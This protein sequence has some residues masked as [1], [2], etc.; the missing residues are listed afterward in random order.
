MKPIS[1]TKRKQLL[2]DYDK[3][4]GPSNIELARKYGVSNSCIRYILKNAGVYVRQRRTLIEQDEVNK[5]K[6]ENNTMKAALQ[7]IADW[8]LPDTGQFW[9]EKKKEPK[10]YT[11]VHGTNGA[12]NVMRCVAFDALGK[13][14]NSDN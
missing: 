3:G 9:D 13:C 11:I 10:S 2:I 1:I 6:Q 8:A 4:N 7:Q 5:L 14:T 12:I